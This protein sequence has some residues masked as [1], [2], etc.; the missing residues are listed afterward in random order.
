MPD[1]RVQYTHPENWYTNCLHGSDKL[2]LYCPCLGMFIQSWF[3]TKANIWYLCDFKNIRHRGC[4]CRKLRMKS[5]KAFQ[6]T[7]K[8]A[9]WFPSSQPYY[10]L[11]LTLGTLSFYC[12]TTVLSLFCR[13]VHG[14]WM[15]MI[16]LMVTDEPKSM[17]TSAYRRVLVGRMNW[18]FANTTLVSYTLPSSCEWLWMT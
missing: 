13:L 2:F 8:S 10:P 4:H 9:Q 15:I 11:E 3:K 16:F 14:F 12:T 6:K 18:G 5:E 1:I 17:S 7:R